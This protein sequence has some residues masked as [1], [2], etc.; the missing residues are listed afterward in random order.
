MCNK[1]RLSL[2]L[3]SFVLVLVLVLVLERKHWK[4]E[5]EDEDEDDN[6]NDRQRNPQTLPGALA[7]LARPSLMQPSAALAM[8]ALPLPKTVPGP[9]CES[10]CACPSCRRRSQENR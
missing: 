8:E 5:H 3:F 6:E 7:A 9:R 1:D 4:V 2:R 10:G